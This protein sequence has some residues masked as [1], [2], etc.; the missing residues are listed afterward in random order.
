MLRFFWLLVA[1]VSFSIPAFTQILNIEMHE[2]CC[3]GC[4]NCALSHI[5]HT[6]PPEEGSI[7]REVTVDAGISYEGV[8]FGHG[9]CDI[10]GDGYPDLFA[11]GHGRPQLY[12][13][14][15]DGTFRSIEIDFFKRY[16]TV[17]GQAVP[18]A[19]FDM[20]GAT[21]GDVNNDGKPD[22]YIPMGGD[23][24]NS[25]GKQNILF[26]N[27]GD[28]LILTN[29]SSDYNLQ[30]SLGRGRVGMWVDQNKDGYLDMYLTNFDRN[31]GQFKSA[32]YLYNPATLQ[33][34][35]VPS[36][37][38]GTP[39][40]SFYFSTLIRD[41][42]NDRNNMIA[43]NQMSAIFEH[44]DISSLPF[45]RTYT[46]T[47][48]G[49]RDITVGD[50]N[51]DGIQDAF[52]VSNRF[53]SEA[54]IKNDTTLQVYLYTKAFASGYATE[55]R[56]SFR[57]EG[58]IRIEATIY[59]YKDDIRSLWRIGRNGIQPST[60]IIE[61]DPDDTRNHGFFNCFLCVGPYIGY[62]TNTGKWEVFI[63]DPIDRA[64]G[65]FRITSANPI[66]DVETHNFSNADIVTSDRLYLQNP[67]GGFRVVNN[68]LSNAPIQTA[69]VSVVAA[70]FDNDMDLDL[71]LATQGAAINYKNLYYENDGAGNFTR[72]EDFGATGSIEGRSGTISTADINNDGFIDVFLENGEGVIADDATALCFNDGPYQLFL[73][74]GNG[75]HWVMFDLMDED[76]PGNK[77]AYGTTVFV[78]AGGKKQIRLKGS[79]IH[80]FGQNDSRLHFGLAGNR[81]VDSVQIFWPDGFL[82]TY[83]CLKADSIYSIRK[84]GQSMAEFLVVPDFDISNFVCFGVSDIRLP[85]VSSDGITGTWFPPVINSKESANYIFTPN[86]GQC[87]DSYS[88][89][90][91][92]VDN[93]GI[94][95]LGESSVCS[96]KELLLTASSDASIIWETGDTAQTISL[97]LN[98]SSTIT[99][100][101]YDD[102][103]CSSSFTKEI[104]VV[105]SPEAP[106][107]ISNSPVLE[108]APIILQADFVEGATYK[109]QGPDGFSSDIQNPVIAVSSL[110]DAGFYQLNITVDECSS[111]TVSVFVEVGESAE[112]SGAIMPSNGT[113]LPALK[114]QANGLSQILVDA[115]LAGQYQMRLNKGSAYE[116]QPAASQTSDLV[117]VGDLIRI[118]QH[119]AGEKPLEGPFD[120]I[121]A[122]VNR[123]MQVD[124]VDRDALQAHLLGNPEPASD[125][126]DWVFV[127]TDYIF[128][129][130]ENPFP[131][132]SS[133][134]YTAVESAIDQDFMGISMG[135]ILTTEQS[136]LESL[137]FSIGQYSV[138]QGDAVVVPVQVSNFR[139]VSGWRLQLIWD[140]EV[141]TLNDI[142][143]GNSGLAVLTGSTKVG[144]GQLTLLWT[145]YPDLS[146]TLAD[147]VQLVQL[148]FSAIGEVGEATQIAFI[149][150][151]AFDPDL[152][153][154]NTETS[155]G[156]IA[157]TAAT[158]SQDYQQKGLLAKLTP[159]PFHHHATLTYI[160]QQ[161]QSCKITIS[162]VTG[163][164]LRKIDVIS[165]VG[166]NTLEVGHGLAAGTYMLSIEAG[167]EL[168]TLKMIILQ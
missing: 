66:V 69:A 128:S 123:S 63:N 121:A 12:M 111:N 60:R 35:Y 166:V 74:K 72:I 107:I 55:H 156:G 122:D 137:K 139:S 14:N 113:P 104:T 130:P 8:T 52:A 138:L 26:L 25:E 108:G 45:Q 22:L 131:Y 95:V 140:S 67:T 129:N 59:P 133:R 28:S 146:T 124:E 39:N 136:D 115:D 47:L 149:A 87:A 23:G 90:I 64:K 162:D 154:I 54:A 4:R 46:N 29:R 70:D 51:G 135:H 31:D 71:L 1:F 7:F 120:L 150:Q 73:N 49:I 41:Y 37:I 65:S 161:Q 15:G 144:E 5:A 143:E 98:A 10:N 164:Q 125:I 100:T 145:G 103:G 132:P 157:I 33:Y 119:L 24:G 30:D 92:I 43:S 142:V 6:H 88:I 151:E 13:N 77:L 116:V 167:S 117:S 56:A 86:P 82:E 17:D 53:V 109:W 48:F 19:F 3:S 62:N 34:D 2:G 102:N 106:S 61:L 76:S 105:P 168:Q 159:N 152:K 158:S 110:N 118:E 42:R 57:T 27:S 163:K 40:T 94:S 68:F 96:G 80:A 127:P 11:N 97:V 16:D 18:V 165:E 153:Q 44:F 85:D 112:I 79:E 50:F 160:L 81:V 155:P 148:E 20:H 32:L 89:D 141:V 91:E 93:P 114:V 78:Y 75:N 101:A 36:T 134:M 147:S 83:R 84:K 9:W 38:T 58:K 21:W 126:S 99:V